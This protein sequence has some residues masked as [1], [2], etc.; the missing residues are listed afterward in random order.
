VANLPPLLFKPL[1]PKPMLL[2]AHLPLNIFFNSATVGFTGA[3]CFGWAKPIHAKSR[4]QKQITGV[5]SLLI[6]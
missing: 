2:H 3:F 4:Q 6:G 1:E 5:F